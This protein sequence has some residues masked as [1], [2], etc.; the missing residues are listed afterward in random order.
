L[1]KRDVPCAY[2][3]AVCE[4]CGEILLYRALAVP[5][6]DKDF[7][8]AHLI[9]PDPGLHRAVPKVVTECYAEAAKIKNLAPNAFAVQ[10][11][12]ALEALCDDRGAKKGTLRHRLQDLASRGEIPPVLAEMTDALRLLGNIGAHATDQ[13]VKPLHVLAIDDFFR[14]IIEY[15]YVAPSKLKEFRDRLEKFG[16]KQAA[17]SDT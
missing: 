10:I 3:V 11:R 12:R 9:W 1:F 17:E 14:A 13:N 8:L 5:V 15:V 16:R 7:S 6:E 2:Y 4:T